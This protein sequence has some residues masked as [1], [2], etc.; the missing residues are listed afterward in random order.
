M[1]ALPGFSGGIL[2]WEG[3]QG[4]GHAAGPPPRRRRR[5][6]RR[7]VLHIHCSSERPPR[8]LPPPPRRLPGLRVPIPNPKPPHFTVGGSLKNFIP[9]PFFFFCFLSRR[10]GADGSPKMKVDRTKLKKT[11]T[12]AVSGV[13]GEVLG[14]FRVLG[15]VLMPFFFF[16]YPPPA[17]RLPGPHREAEGVR[18]RAAA[19]RAA[20]DQDMEHR[21][22]ARPPPQKK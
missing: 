22:G 15:G 3:V 19:G 5:A 9:P 16:F 21:Q 12:E 10:S 14:F 4:G 6:S 7:G 1:G 11:P 20:A 18:R 13:F 8:H 2:N 17:R